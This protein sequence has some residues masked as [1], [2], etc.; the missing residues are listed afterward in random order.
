MGRAMG[1][2]QH[3]VAR[4]ITGRQP[5]KRNEGGWEYPPLAAEM[6]EAGFEYIGVYI[7]KSQNTIAQYIATQPILD[8]C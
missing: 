4:R 7:L 3:G 6:E 8:L 5:R 2:F 1:S